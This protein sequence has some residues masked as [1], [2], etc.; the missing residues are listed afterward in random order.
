[1]EAEKRIEKALMD[2]VRILPDDCRALIAAAFERETSPAGRKALEYILKNI[3]IAENSMLPLC[4]DCG[5]SY[6]FVELGRESSIRPAAIER[7]VN[8]AALNA[9]QKA[10]YRKSCV[11]DPVYDRINTGTDLPVIFDWQLRDG[12]G[13]SVSFLLKGFGSENCSSVRM[14]RPT[15]GEDGVVAAVLDIVRAAGGKPCP[16][17]FLGIGIGATMDKAAVLSK[18]ALVR[19]ADRPNSDQRYAALEKRILDEVNCLGIGPGGLGGI[20]TCLAAAVEYL[21]THIAGLPVA[22]SIN[23]WA[24]RKAFIEIEEGQL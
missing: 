24:D 11:N 15:D 19:P 3:A 17:M 23:C 22:V 5:L 7:A 2:A 8:E 6:A 14:I 10:F 9:A 13:A 20:N 18:K 21:P 1:M 12:K 16:P 4:Q